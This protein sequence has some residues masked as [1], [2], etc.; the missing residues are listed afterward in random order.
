[1]QLKPPLAASMAVDSGAGLD[2]LL[3]E[4]ARHAHDELRRSGPGQPVEVGSERPAWIYG[5]LG[6]L[7][8]GAAA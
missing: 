7:D 8:R 1:M 4:S 2:R 6:R 5:G 3:D